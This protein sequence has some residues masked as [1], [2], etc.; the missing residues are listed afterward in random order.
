MYDS[1]NSI[2]ANCFPFC[3]PRER[4]F[5]QTHLLALLLGHL[6]SGTV[7]GGGGGSSIV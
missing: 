2:N 6:A 3:E 7:A 4:F 1:A 5:C